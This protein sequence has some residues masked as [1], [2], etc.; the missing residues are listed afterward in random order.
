MTSLILGFAVPAFADDT[1]PVDKTVTKIEWKIDRVTAPESIAELRA[2][3]DLMKA[4]VEKVMPST[5]GMFIG[6]SA[7]SGV[8]VSDDGL[9]LTAAHVIGKPNADIQFILPDGQRV[10]GKSLGLNRGWDSGMAKITSKPPKSAKWPGAKDGKWPAVEIGKSAELKPGQYVIALGHPG[11]PKPDRKP[12]VRLGQFLRSSRIGQSL[13]TDCTLVGG[14]S[15]GPLFDMAGKLI[16]IHSRIGLDLE[17]NVHVPVEA[18]Q[19]DWKDMLA[20]DRVNQDPPVVFGVKFDI[21]NDTNTVVEVR[22][23]SPAEAAGVMVGDRITR[24][25]KVEIKRANDVYDLLFD[26]KVG[27]KVKIELIR[28]SETIKT[29]AT[30]AKRPDTDKKP[31]RR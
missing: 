9:V 20:E 8:I 5:V 31:K 26:L 17:S 6:Q 23:E 19:K 15:G 21:D 18:F 13:T 22:P 1:K 2:M 28:G 14:D 27:D 16:G 24:F 4:T 30:L 3:Q 7:G 11:G 25:N 12:P 29:E 10:Y